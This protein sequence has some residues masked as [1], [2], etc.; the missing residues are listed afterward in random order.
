MPEDIVITDPKGMIE[1]TSRIVDDLECSIN[2][3]LHLPRVDFDEILICGMGGSAIGGDIVANCLFTL[4]DTPIRVIRFPELPVWANEKT[5]V[6]VSSYSGNTLETLSVYDQAVEH[7]CKIICITSGGE[8]KKKADS[9]SNSVVPVKSGI[10]P[11]NAV[12]YTVG[13]MLNIIKSVGGPD[14]TADVNKCIPSL[15]KY[16]SSLKP[17]DSEARKIAAIIREGVP[18]I[19][20]TESF[21]SIAGRWRAQF[22]ENS[23]IL[24]FDGHIPETNHSDIVGLVEHNGVSLKPILLVEYRQSKLMKD[25]I[26]ATSSTLKS[27]GLKPYIVRVS[28][29]TV[30]E[31]IFRA[32]ILGDFISLHLAFFR[33]LDPSDVS[34]ISVFKTTL[35]NKLFGR[36]KKQSKS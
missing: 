5:L 34:S 35:F 11:R 6:I 21:S 15:K 13:Y 26:G 30:F 22:N 4:S 29:K 3:K 2:T 18:V 32:M 9:N 10:Q 20:S 23:K 24:A 8:L 16:I 27:H 12:G 1:E 17:V 19:Y 28:G 25:I 33:E 14:I 7:G 36:K 31:R